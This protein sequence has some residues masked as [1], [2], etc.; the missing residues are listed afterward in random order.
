VS[1]PVILESHGVFLRN[2]AW[3]S[4]LAVI[5]V[6]AVVTVSRLLQEMD[7]ADKPTVVL[8]SQVVVLIMI[9]RL[10]NV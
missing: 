5:L 2:R 3:L 1:A 9:A 10:V 4:H 7:G 8:L 6:T